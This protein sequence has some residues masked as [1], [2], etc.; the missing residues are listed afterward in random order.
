MKKYLF[1]LLFACSLI[2]SAKIIQAENILRVDT[3]PAQITQGDGFEITGTF[4]SGPLPGN[5]V[6][7]S[8]WPGRV[9]HV[10]GATLRLVSWTENKIVIAGS[11][12]G[13]SQGLNN[14][15]VI[16]A[17]DSSNIFSIN[18]KVLCTAASW[19]CDNWS[20][21]SAS[22]VQTR[23]CEKSFW[24]TNES[25]VTQQ[26]YCEGGVSAPQTSQSCTYT[27]PVCTSWTYSDWS[28]CQSNSTKTRSV[29]SSS[30][31]NC[32][33][34]TPNLT[35]SCAYT[36][37]QPITPPPV[38]QPPQP[39][40]TADT[41]SCGDWN[42]CSLSGIQ[43]R[44]CRKTFDCSA[45]EDIP[46][47][48]SRSCTA[49]QQTQ[50]QAENINREQIFK[51]TVKLECPM[52]DGKYYSQGSGTVIDQYGTILTNRHVIRGTIGS[53]RV[54]FIN[55]ENDDPSFSEIADVKNTSPDQSSN[56]DMALLKIRN[57]RNKQFT[58]IDILKGNS[59]NLRSG[60]TI[61]PFGYPDENLFGTT[62]TFTEGPYSGKGTTMNLGGY[63]MI[64]SGFFKTTATV[65]H[66]NSG[67]GAYQ[68]KTGLFMGIPTLGT[69]LDPKIPSRVNYILSINTIK[70]WLSSLG[71]NYSVSANNYSNLGNYL[72]SSVKIEDINLSSLRALDAPT[73]VEIISGK[74]EEKI[75][76]SINGTT[77]S[78]PAV[79]PSIIKKSGAS[80]QKESPQV[81]SVPP[82]ISKPII[83]STT[84]KS[85]E[86]KIT[87]DKK[88]E[89][90][91]DNK[92]QEK[93]VKVSWPKRFLNWLAN[94][95]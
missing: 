61:L 74:T 34:G 32:S 49:P 85:S 42:A 14:F 23:S 33:G 3:Y 15:Q 84:S 81:N 1:I 36:P 40:C 44:S 76:E 64:V 87:E 41:W 53:C 71:G 27:P 21:C 86:S 20:A 28:D 8:N 13:A 16:Y 17:G 35:Q 22:G 80:P 45:V 50:D 75:K 77:K 12:F 51:A 18:V 37:P 95:F 59:D 83:A 69:S 57:S 10:N 89:Q 4:V 46:P 63:S 56:G 60:D 39:S 2:F 11:A 43:N 65:D 58:A 38:Y 88:P 67:G 48:T 54:G 62:I 68:K 29:V 55:D 73:P 91:V 19:G 94:L 25:G 52:P 78:S 26:N 24:N 66:G 5:D 7:G 79:P 6:N 30:P 93:Q 47:A 92:V 31:S 72:S 82:K 70:T 90:S 9:V